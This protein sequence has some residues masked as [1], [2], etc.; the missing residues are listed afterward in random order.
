MQLGVQTGFRFVAGGV[1][2]KEF[3]RS[4]ALGR[5]SVTCRNVPFGPINCASWIRF[6]S[7]RMLRHVSAQ[8]CSAMRSSNNATTVNAM[9][10]WM[11]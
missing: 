6:R 9:C 5:G 7:S 11:R 2:R 3:R 10:A 4:A 8:S 1:I